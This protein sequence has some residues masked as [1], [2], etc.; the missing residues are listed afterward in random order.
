MPTYSL[1][2]IANG[3][4]ILTPPLSPPSPLSHLR[5][6]ARNMHK[7]MGGLDVKGVQPEMLISSRSLGAFSICPVSGRKFTQ[8]KK[9]IVRGTFLSSRGTWKLNGLGTQRI[10]SPPLRPP[11]PLLLQNIIKLHFI[12]PWHPSIYPSSTSDTSFIHWPR[13]LLRSRRSSHHHNL[14]FLLQVYSTLLYIP[15]LCISPVASSSSSPA[16][17]S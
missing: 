9:T 14:S 1:L 8:K 7:N 15:I 17:H 5:I 16:I 11:R 12:V 13:R 3:K 4:L 10:T 2:Q 6:H